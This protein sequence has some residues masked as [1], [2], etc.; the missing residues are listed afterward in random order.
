GDTRARVSSARILSNTLLRT[1]RTSRGSVRCTDGA[2]ACVARLRAN[3][4]HAG[5]REHRA[6]VAQA[7]RRA[8]LSSL[9]LR[10]DG[11]RRDCLDVGSI[12]WLSHRRNELG[13]GARDSQA[14]IAEH[15]CSIRRD[16]AETFFPVTHSKGLD[17]VDTEGT[18][19]T[20]WDTHVAAEFAAKDADQA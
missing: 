19:S 14:C 10:G 7:R 6:V 1:S 9:P 17:N 12:S 5:L 18:L 4:Y 13:H 11:A 8:R 16:G 20:V 2:S 15:S 3:R